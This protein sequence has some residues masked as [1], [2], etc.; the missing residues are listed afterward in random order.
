MLPPLMR[1]V[2]SDGR[3]SCP[4]CDWFIPTTNAP[5]A[6]AIGSFQRQMAPV[7]R[8]IGSFRRQILPP[9][10]RLVHSDD[11]CSLR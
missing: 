6:D 7:P 9:L 11:K 3:C 5:S 1:L 8:A 2:R 10:M 4:S